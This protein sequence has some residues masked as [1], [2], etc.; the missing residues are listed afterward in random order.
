MCLN[1]LRPLRS[2]FRV[3]INIPVPKPVRGP[4]AR[5]RPSA[6]GFRCT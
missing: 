6:A 2:M 1:N 3:R 5:E 4:S